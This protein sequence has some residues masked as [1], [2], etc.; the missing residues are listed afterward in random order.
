MPVDALV[1][2][3]ELVGT[4]ERQNP[5]PAGFRL[6]RPARLAVQAR[7]AE[8]YFGVVGIERQALGASAKRGG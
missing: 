6:G 8:Q 4:L 1:D 5:P 3:A 2:A 7:F